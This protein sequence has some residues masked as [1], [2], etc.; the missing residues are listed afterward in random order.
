MQV[1]TL[2]G[3]R[4]LVRGGTAAGAG[5]DSVDAGARWRVNVGWEYAL[6]VGRSVG[7]EMEEF[8]AE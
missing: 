4:L 6:T 3:L 5:G 8:V 2:T 7:F 1:A